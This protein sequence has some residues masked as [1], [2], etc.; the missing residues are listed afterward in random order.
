MGGYLNVEGM[1]GE[2]PDNSLPGVVKLART[3][4]ADALGEFDDDVR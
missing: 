2:L 1:S 3:R 4:N